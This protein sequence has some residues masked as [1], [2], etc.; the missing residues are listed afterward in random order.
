[1]LHVLPAAGESVA[2]DVPDDVPR[3]EAALAAL[4]RRNGAAR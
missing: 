3:A 1:L 4:A 2:V